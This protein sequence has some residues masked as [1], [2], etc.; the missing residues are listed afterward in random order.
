LRFIK[1]DVFQMRV[2]III[3][4]LNM[5]VSEQFYKEP[6]FDIL[7]KSKNIEVRLYKENIIAK[8]SVPIEDEKIDNSMFRT[9]ASYIFGENERRQR[10]PMTAP[11]TTIKN[12]ETYDMIFYMLNV[13]NIDELPNPTNPNI[14]FEKLNLGK[15]V[16]IS[17]SWLTNDFRVKYYKKQLKKYVEDNGYTAISPFMLNRYDS[18]WT[19]PWNR[20]NEI[21]VK[22]K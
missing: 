22:I 10:I 19:L 1:N 16:S 8:T 11:V 2:I 4:F 9:L 5:L 3:F 13:E 6:S 17:F 12:E 21:L 20:R 7:K 18:P 15:C 14:E